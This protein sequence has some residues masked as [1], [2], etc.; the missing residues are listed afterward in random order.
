MN[1]PYIEQDCI[2]E[3]EGKKFEA[4]GAVVTDEWVIGYP[5]LDSEHVGA[6]G[7][8]T[9]WHGEPLGTVRI[10]S[11]WRTPKSFVSSHMFQMEARVNGK[12]YTGRSAGNGVIFRGRVK[13]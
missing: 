3:H 13:K 8:L 1:T 9:S 4:G 6:T 2:V 11:K 5:K 12:T 7:T 10:T